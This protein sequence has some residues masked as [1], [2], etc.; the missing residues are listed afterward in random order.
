MGFKMEQRTQEGLTWPIERQSAAHIA[1]E[2]PGVRRAP[3]PAR[4]RPSVVLK[5]GKSRPFSKPSIPVLA[6][7]HAGLRRYP[8]A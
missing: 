7:K 8:A 3:L 2:M 4:K 1:P 6:K 5:L